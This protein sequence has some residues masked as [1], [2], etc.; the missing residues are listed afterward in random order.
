MGADERDALAYDLVQSDFDAVERGG[1]RAAWTD[2][3][4]AVVVSSLV[5]DARRRYDAED[6]VRAASDREVENA[7]DEPAP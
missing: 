4:T 7:R 2:D 5:D 1:Y 3:D 6:L